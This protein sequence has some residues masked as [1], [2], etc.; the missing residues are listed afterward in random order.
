M[1]SQHNC[2]VRYREGLPVHSEA[3]DGPC[4]DEKVVDV[5]HDVVGM[6]IE[7]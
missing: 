4:D 6:V 7:G 2:E 5:L 1:R 3:F